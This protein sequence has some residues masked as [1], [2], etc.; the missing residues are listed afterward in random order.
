M[1]RLTSSNT[2]TDSFPLE[3]PN[4]QLVALIEGGRYVVD[5]GSSVS[6][7][8]GGYINIL[9][10]QFQIPQE[11][12]GID[13]DE[14]TR[15][16]GA[17]VDGILGAD[18][19]DLTQFSIK[20]DEGVLTLDTNIK[21]PLKQRIQA[22]TFLGISQLQV[23]TLTGETL[24]LFFDTGAK[25]SYLT[26]ELVRGRKP[27]AKVKDYYPYFGVFETDVWEMG[28]EIA[29]KALH[30]RVGVLPELLR[31]SLKHV[32]PNSGVLGTEVLKTFDLVSDMS[33]DWYAFL[34]RD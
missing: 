19:L 10:Q 20:R 34:P 5:T 16:V 33:E 25:M 29:G 14:L 13:A 17:P 9:R 28:F 6:Y 12:M 31:Q 27:I 11:Y 26:P 8:R 15:M 30:L 4:D 3:W 32:G 21:P 24:N 2:H 22:T 7:G 1:R 23:W 18:L